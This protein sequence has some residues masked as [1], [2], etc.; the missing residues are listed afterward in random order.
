MG[1]WTGLGRIRVVAQTT[2]YPANWAAS[3]LYSSVGRASGFNCL[4]FVRG[5]RDALFSL[6]K[7]GASHVC[8][9]L[10]FRH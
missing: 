2:V 7:V 4:L 8:R 6:T 9:F 10:M 1:Y 5:S 3:D